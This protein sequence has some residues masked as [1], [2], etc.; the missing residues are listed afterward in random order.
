ML[1]TIVGSNRANLL[2][3]MASAVKNIEGDY[4]EC[5][6]YNGG[7]AARIHSVIPS[8]KKLVLFDSFEGLPDISKHDNFHKKHDF[9]DVNFDSVKSY[10]EPHKNVEIVKAWVPDIFSNYIDT[11]LCFVHIDLDLY[12]GYKSTLEF[13]WP[14]LSSGGVIIFD[15]YH[16]PSCIGSKVAVDEFVS[17]K[18]ISLKSR[19]DSYWIIKE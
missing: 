16:A 2:T 6:V 12:E 13:T 15:D 18:N 11:K 8:T 14:R 7:S 5:G 10:F 19:G 17:K 4:W 9:N 1:P 3:E